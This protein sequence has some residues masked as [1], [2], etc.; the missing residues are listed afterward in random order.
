LPSNFT[1]DPSWDPDREFELVFIMCLPDV[2]LVFIV[3]TVF[4]VSISNE[5]PGRNFPVAS[6][7]VKAGLYIDDAWEGVI[8]KYGYKD[9]AK[10]C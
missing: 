7:D 9:S 10:V 5:D 3:L 6:S 4:F 2:C 1:P 8:Y